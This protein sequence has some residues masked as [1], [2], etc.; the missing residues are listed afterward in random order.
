MP[1]EAET[2]SQNEGLANG[3]AN[4]A[5]GFANHANGFA[6]LANG[7]ANLANGFANHENGFANHEKIQSGELIRLASQ[8]K[9]L[10]PKAT[11][12]KAIALYRR[13]DS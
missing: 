7:F 4:L 3:F 8:K 10:R 9:S 5:N 11:Q 1:A 6:N 12:L 2:F 13:R